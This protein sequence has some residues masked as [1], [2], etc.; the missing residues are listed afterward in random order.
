[1]CGE[2]GVLPRP[3][4]LLLHQPQPPTAT[5]GTTNIAEVYQ[6]YRQASGVTS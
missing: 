3:I 2:R 4:R 6:W 5:T 1:M